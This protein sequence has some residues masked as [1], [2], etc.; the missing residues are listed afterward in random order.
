M[1]VVDASVF[2]HLVLET[3]KSQAAEKILADYEHW[4]APEIAELEV[5]NGI[6][7]PLLRGEMSEVRALEALE[8]FHA[9]GIARLETASLKDEIWALRHN[10]TPYD[11]AYVAIARALGVPFITSDKKMG[12]AAQNIVPVLTV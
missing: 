7:E 5:M 9:F 6:R 2:V 3:D 4:I 8:A 11:A 10:L 1:I 12:N